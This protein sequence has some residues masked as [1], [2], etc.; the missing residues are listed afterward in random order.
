MMYDTLSNY[1]NTIAK[2]S[3]QSPSPRSP[4]SSHLS[5]TRSH[6]IFNL[7]KQVLSA[8][9]PKSGI[10]NDEKLENNYPPDAP[11]LAD[12]IRG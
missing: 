6:G 12:I 4:R 5:S 2:G 10:S 9:I 7:Y 1:D 11:T 3:A 8:G